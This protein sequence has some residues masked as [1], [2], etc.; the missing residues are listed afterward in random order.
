MHMQYIC[1][2]AIIDIVTFALYIKILF[3]LTK[4]LEANDLVKDTMR[5]AQ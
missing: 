1:M 3:A 5:V 2:M 4:F